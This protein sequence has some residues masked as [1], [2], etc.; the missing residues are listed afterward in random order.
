MNKL[1]GFSVPSSQTA[2]NFN[3]NEPAI[4]VEGEPILK[5][6]SYLQ[7]ILQRRSEN[8]IEPESPS[9]VLHILKQ[10]VK[11]NAKLPDYVHDYEALRDIALSIAKH[12][13]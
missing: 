11:E 10:V 9:E 6:L 1:Q 7:Y 2:I 3:G 12:Q 5:K 8:E 4:P 13:C